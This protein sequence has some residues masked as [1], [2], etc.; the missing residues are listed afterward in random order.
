MTDGPCNRFYAA[1]DEDAEL[2]SALQRLPAA[3][4]TG[5]WHMAERA[6]RAAVIAA[7]CRALWCA[8][9]GLLPGPRAARTPEGLSPAAPGHLPGATA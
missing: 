8:L 1:L 7:A 9:R 5:D 3:A 6:M 4:R 2:A